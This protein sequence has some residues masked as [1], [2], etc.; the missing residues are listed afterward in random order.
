M[1]AARIAALLA[2]IATPAMAGGDITGTS[3]GYTYFNKPGA[4]LAMH[5]AEVREC[6]QLAGR[7]HQPLGAMPSTTIVAPAGVSPVAAGV[8]GAIGMAIA[9][10]IEQKMADNKGNPVNVEHCM[11]V[12]G[13][14]VVRIDDEEGKALAAS[15]RKAKAASLASWVGASEPHGHIVRTF[16][17]ELAD[18]AEAFAPANKTGTSLGTDIDTRVAATGRPLTQYTPPPAGS[19]PPP[20]PSSAKSPKP[21]KDT[22]LGG[23]PAGM[24]LIVVNVSGDDE[25]SLVLQRMGSIIGQPA[26]VD[27]QPDEID[28]VRPHKTY[29][30]PGESYGTTAVFAVPPGRWRVAS[31]TVNWVTLNLCLGGPAFNLRPGEAVYAGSFSRRHLAPDMDMAP[32]K[33]AFPGLSPLPETLQPAN[34]VNGTQGQCYGAYLY[35]LELPGAPYV[36]TY[37]FGGRASNPTATAAAGPAGAGGP[38]RPEGAAQPAATAAAPPER[39]FAPDAPITVDIPPAEPTNAATAPPAPAGRAPAASTRPG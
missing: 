34:W 26:Y 36:D 18:G 20:R 35:A 19:R 25:I 1:R 7:L 12:K 39:S 2:V 4:D 16:G 30:K 11:V 10:A 5:D 28:V 3:D 8:G 13:W 9:M 32:A 14:R 31:I 24:G 22:E 27:G 38:S 15:D 33:A 6:K 21:L 23:I 29:A 37:Q 17:N